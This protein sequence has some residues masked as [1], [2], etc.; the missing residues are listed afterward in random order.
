LLAAPSDSRPQRCLPAFCLPCAALPPNCAA[1]YRQIEFRLM[2]HFSG[3]AGL[4]RIFCD[5][6]ADPFAL[7]AA[8]W[9][10]TPAHQASSCSASVDI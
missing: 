8:Q 3:D 9:L 7:L 5:D 1:D 6:A 2:A 10:G 4:M